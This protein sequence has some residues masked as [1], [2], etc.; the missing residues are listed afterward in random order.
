MALHPFPRRNQAL[1]PYSDQN[2]DMETE[3]EPQPP[4]PEPN[5]RGLTVEEELPPHWAKIS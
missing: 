5:Y 4:I 3:A 1:S 2:W